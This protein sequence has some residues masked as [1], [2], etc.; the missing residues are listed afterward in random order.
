MHLYG[1]IIRR[2]ADADAS[3]VADVWL[4]SFTAALPSVRRAHLKA[5]TEGGDEPGTLSFSDYNEPVAVTA[6]PAD[7]TVDVEKVKAA[8]S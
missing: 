1:L 6:P 2:A 8:G 7:Q 5:V 4:R 3:P